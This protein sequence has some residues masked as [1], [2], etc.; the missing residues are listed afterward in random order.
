MDANKKMK[1]L[2]GKYKHYKNKNYEVLHSKNSILN[3]F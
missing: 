2:L 1:E 3:N